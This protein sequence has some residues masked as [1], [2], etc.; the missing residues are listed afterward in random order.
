MSQKHIYWTTNMSCNLYAS[1]DVFDSFHFTN[2]EL[3]LRLRGN[4]LI[5]SVLMTLAI[6]NKERMLGEK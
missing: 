5:T 3:Q 1:R 4:N 6:I 2:D